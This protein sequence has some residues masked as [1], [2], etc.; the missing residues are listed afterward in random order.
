[1]I[2]TKL[3]IKALNLAYNFHKNQIDEFGIPVVFNIYNVADKTNSE[4]SICAA[5][6][7]QAVENKKTNLS[8]FKKDFP[9]EVT[10][11]IFILLTDDA[12]A[13]PDYIR[14]IKTNKI[15]T[16]IKIIEIEESIKRLKINSTKSKAQLEKYEFALKILK[17]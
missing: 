5:L 8:A 15:A 10:D 4:V 3:T 9:F 13:Y 7:Y 2:Y 1:M 12:L 16:E 11:T 17:K 14:R 6:L